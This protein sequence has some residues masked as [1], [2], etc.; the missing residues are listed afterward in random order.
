MILNRNPLNTTPLDASGGVVG[1]NP[2]PAQVTSSINDGVWTIKLTSVSYTP[3]N[4]SITSSVTGTTII[5]M[6]Q[7]PV[8]PAHMDVVLQTSP[9]LHYGYHVATTPTPAVLA[10]QVPPRIWLGLDFPATTP[11]V[12]IVN[13]PTGILRVNFEQTVQQATVLPLVW[14]N[15]TMLHVGQEFISEPG[16]I[17][18]VTTTSPR[19]SAATGYVSVTASVSTSSSVNI[20]AVDLSSVTAKPNPINLAVQVSTLEDT[21]QVILST[22][23][24]AA[25]TNTYSSAKLTNVVMGSIAITPRIPIVRAGI[26]LYGVEVTEI[27]PPIQITPILARVDSAINDGVL[28][29]VQ[30]SVKVDLHK[31][32]G[33]EATTSVSY[34]SVS[35]MGSATITP[36][37]AKVYSEVLIGSK[38]VPVSVSPIVNTYSSVA[39]RA[40]LAPMVISG[41]A[42]SSTSSVSVTDAYYG[43][44][45][46]TP[47]AT[48]VESWIFPPQIKTT[49]LTADPVAA[50]ATSSVTLNTVV[51]STIKVANDHLEVLATANAGT[52]VMSSVSVQPVGKPDAISSVEVGEVTQP[53]EVVSNILIQTTSSVIPGI[54]PVLGSV[55]I[56]PLSTVTTSSAQGQ[57]K[58]GTASKTGQGGEVVTTDNRGQLNVDPLSRPGLNSITVQN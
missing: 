22:V 48:S 47:H 20:T 21:L 1:V 4:P 43:T 16:V 23:H 42:A 58:Y 10:W 24:V 15:P 28:S 3:A 32:T 31:D 5:S 51:L 46:L 37:P 30:S 54:S 38:Y 27:P 17:D 53:N 39:G 40:I 41:L 6:E 56:T 34:T 9:S 7:G 12:A 55:T 19:F 14:Q 11:A 25:E 50:S 35:V 44:L 52:V 29:V 8:V 18:I 33:A 26:G 49:G 2:A 57:F 36:P 45:H 13:Q